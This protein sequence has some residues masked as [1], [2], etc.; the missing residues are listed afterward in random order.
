[1][2]YRVEKTRCKSISDYL[3]RWLRSSRNLRDGL[4]SVIK[5]S[6]NVGWMSESGMS[7]N[8]CGKKNKNDCVARVSEPSN[9]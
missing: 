4:E 1:M 3:A 7:G 6:S 5:C 8:D 9:L 2:L